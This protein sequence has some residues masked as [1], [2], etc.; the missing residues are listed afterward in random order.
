MKFYYKGLIENKEINKR[1]TII[2]ERLKNIIMIKE[3]KNKFLLKS[4]FYKLY[5][6]GI[7]SELKNEK[8][9]FIMDEKK[10]NKEKIKKI[11]ISMENKTYKH[12]F[13]I[14][15]DCFE[16]W[17]LMSKI[18]GM[19]A[20]T[21]EKKR[22]KRQKQRMKKKIENKS[23]NNY[24]TNN[25]ILHLG[26]NNS[27]NFINKEKDKD[28]VICNE[29]IISDFSGGYSNRDNKIDKNMKAAD[30]IENIF[31]KTAM[32]YKSLENNK[33]DLNKN[34]QVNLKGNIEIEK[35][36]KKEI[37]QYNDINNENDNEYEE[38]S[39]DSFGI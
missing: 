30:K 14:I 32:N 36:D 17:N 2:K 5:Y 27:I 29:H 15:R 25:N 28:I 19:K 33:K 4:Y 6:K 20:I 37:K 9:K 13:L 12:N 35:N 1:N 34:N 39:G 21:D 18:L 10:R 24:L 11:F 22:K 8:D 31:Y 23:S 38:D 26:K 16:K 3:K 7:I